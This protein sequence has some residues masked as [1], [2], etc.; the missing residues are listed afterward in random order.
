MSSHTH[1]TNGDNQGAF[2]FTGVS[3]TGNISNMDFMSD[4]IKSEL[5]KTWTQPVPSRIITHYNLNEIVING[6]VHTKIK[7]CSIDSCNQERLYTLTW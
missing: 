4:L 6:F 2:E 3:T 5:K 7:K 1:S